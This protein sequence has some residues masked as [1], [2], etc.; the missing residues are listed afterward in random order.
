LEFHVRTLGLLN[1]LLG[2]FSGVGGLILFMLFSTQAM[3]GSYGQVAGHIFTAW[4]LLMLVLAIPSIVL[5]V[6]LLHFRPWARSIGTVVAILEL[7]S[8]PIGTMVGLYAL[9]VLLTR[10]TDPLF[11]RRYAPPRDY[12]P[13]K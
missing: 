2:A 5:G 6:G 11:S 4:V 10:E 13:L 3:L 1:I 7:L 12:P 8:F 9:W